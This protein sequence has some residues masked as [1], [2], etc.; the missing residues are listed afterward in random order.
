MKVRSLG[1]FSIV[2]VVL[3]ILKLCGL[4]AISWWWVFAPV[5]LGFL[6]GSV[7]LLVVVSIGIVMWL[8]DRGGSGDRRDR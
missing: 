2:F 6:I 1:L 5:V 3:L 7:I 4:T 8:A